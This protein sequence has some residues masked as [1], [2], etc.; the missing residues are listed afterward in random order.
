MSNQTIPIKVRIKGMV[1]INAIMTS[2]PRVKEKDI[3]NKWLTFH[4]FS[5]KMKCQVLDMIANN[6]KGPNMEIQISILD[7]RLTPVSQGEWYE[8]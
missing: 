1:S 2:K 5:E 8:D 4:A 7:T 6:A 3:P